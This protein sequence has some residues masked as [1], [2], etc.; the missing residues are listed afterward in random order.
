MI[1]V[2]R[3][4]DSATVTGTSAEASK[5]LGEPRDPQRMAADIHLLA[6]GEIEEYDLQLVAP[7]NRGKVGERTAGTSPR[8]VRKV[9]AEQ[10]TARR[11]ATAT[12]V[13]L[14]HLC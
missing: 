1:L 5:F 2:P 4:A 14:A 12:N 9:A 8:W 3:Q 7:R 6:D 10:R 13:A 11:S